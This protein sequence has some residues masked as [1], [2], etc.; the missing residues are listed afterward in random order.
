MARYLFTCWPFVGHVNSQVSVAKALQARGHEVAFYTGESARGILEQEG[1]TVLPFQRVDENRVWKCVKEVEIGA[2]DGRQSAR[3]V[4]RAF[5]E[6][7]VETIPG[8]VEDLS[9]LVGDWRP[10]ALV[11]DLSMWGPILI[12]WET[13]GIPVALSS[14]FMGPLIPGPDAPPWGFGLP[15]PRTHRARLLARVI[16]VATDLLARGFQKQV[17]RMRASYGLSALGCSVNVFTGR[18]PLYLVGSIPELDYNRRDLPPS[19]HYVGPCV[20]SKPTGEPP[21]SWFDE[22]SRDRPWVHVTESTLRYGTPF[23]LRTAAQGLANLPVEAI[24]TTGRHRDPEA[25][26]LGP[27]APNIRVERWVSH[28]DLLPQCSAVVTT[29]GAATLIASMQAG[30][31]VVVIPTTWDKPD[32]AQRIVEAGAGIRL[33]PRRCS[34]AKLRTAVERVLNEPSFRVQAQRLARKLAMAPGPARAAELLESMT[35]SVPA[36]PPLSPVNFCEIDTGETFGPI[37]R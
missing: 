25:L 29:G 14:T 35:G 31:P 4:A 6:W 3:L 34:P 21:P 11:T 20:W 24:L 32:N 19:V 37:L 5:R 22:L 30:V 36:S 9:S 33:D 1:L 18:L 26:D 2:P 8:Q 15:S 16:T 13:T 28:S 12:L 17:N 7:L 27:R 10:D 23:V